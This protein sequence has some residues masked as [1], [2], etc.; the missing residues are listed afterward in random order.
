[1][2]GDCLFYIEVTQ[3]LESETN[4]DYGYIRYVEKFDRDFQLPDMTAQQ[5]HIVL[6]AVK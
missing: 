5:M 1:V 6:A 4:K 3:L 2:N